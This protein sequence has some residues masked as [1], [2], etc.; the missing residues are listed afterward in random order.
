[1]VTD[2]FADPGKFNVG[3]TGRHTLRGPD[4]DVFDAARFRHIPIQQNH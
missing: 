2:P 3:D 4:T 1:V